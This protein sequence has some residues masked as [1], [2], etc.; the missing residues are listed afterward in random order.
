MQNGEGVIS[1]GIEGTEPS[2]FSGCTPQQVVL[3]D[4]KPGFI[5]R[6]SQVV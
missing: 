5:D 4:E 1:S 3:A 6:G 2:Y